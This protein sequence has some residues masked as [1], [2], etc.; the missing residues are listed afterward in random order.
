[1]RA[2]GTP[3]AIATIASSVHLA[4]TLVHRGKRADICSKCGT[5]VH[6]TVRTRAYRSIVRRPFEILISA[7]LVGS[8]PWYIARNGRL[9]ARHLWRRRRRA[10]RDARELRSRAE[11][12]SLAGRD[13]AR[14]GAPA[15]R[16][17]RA[18]ARV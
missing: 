6:E 13:A 17:S 10:A 3:P 16:R 18:F 2:S 14:P 9:H 12:A 11:R 8:T 15:D 5:A 7:E 1:M 4:T